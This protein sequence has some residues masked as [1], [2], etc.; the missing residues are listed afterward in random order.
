MATIIKQIH[1]RWYH[2]FPEL[3]LS[4]QEFYALVEKQISSRQVKSIRAK[5]IKFGG[6]LSKR[7][8]LRVQDGEH[9]FDICAAP[10]GTGY[11]VSW[12]MGESRQSIKDLLGKIPILGPALDNYFDSKTYFQWDVLTMFQE[13]VRTSI[14]EAI[15]GVT[16]E[17]GLRK[18]S[19]TERLISDKKLFK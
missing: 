11:F 12:W 13:C 8:Y 10:Y 18:L 2:Y 7:E 17:K 15:D 4:A 9:I 19:E 14:L 6:L 5:R 1:S 16:T 3:Q